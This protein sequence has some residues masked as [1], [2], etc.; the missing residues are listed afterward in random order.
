MTHYC[1]HCWAEIDEGTERCPV[2]GKPIAEPEAGFVDKLIAALRHPEPTRAGL[3]VH[4][5]GE[6]LREPRAI[7]PLIDLVQARPDAH[8]LKLAV[9]ALGHFGDA[10]AVPALVDLL[11]DPTAVV[12]ARLAAVDALQQVGGE[13]ADQALWR[14]MDSERPSI[15]DAARRVADPKGF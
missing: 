2:C 15:R 7:E 5:L 14:A 11:E 9:Q 1:P 8:V 10:R 13:A 4:I 12:V 3:A 6:M